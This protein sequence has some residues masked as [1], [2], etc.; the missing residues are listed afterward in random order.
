MS[1]TRSAKA[2]NT[3]AV[4]VKSKTPS[5]PKQ[6]VARVN[7]P[8]VK[9]SQNTAP[10]AQAS[11]ATKP[12]LATTQTAAELKPASKHKII[13]DLLMHQGASIMTLMQV[14]GWQAHSVRGFISGTIKNKLGLPVTSKKEDGVLIY[15]IAKQ[16]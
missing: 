10:I 3:K 2:T 5:T 13:I 8:A 6:A 15:S 4:Q 11:K 12:A 7:K 14:T 16:K 9:S 1:I